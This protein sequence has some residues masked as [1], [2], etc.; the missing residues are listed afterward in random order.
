MAEEWE[1]VEY[2]QSVTI[3]MDF[4]KTPYVYLDEYK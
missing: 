4:W 3:M 1:I 2:R